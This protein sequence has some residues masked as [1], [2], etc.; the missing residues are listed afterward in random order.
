MLA[1]AT[2]PNESINANA[3]FSPVTFR[4]ISRNLHEMRKRKKK[5]WPVSA[6]SKKIATENLQCTDRPQ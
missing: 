4:K 5:R 2:A 3:F 1:T 6:A